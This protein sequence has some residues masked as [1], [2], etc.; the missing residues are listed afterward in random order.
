MIGEH[1]NE[2]RW[3]A[4]IEDI[5]RLMAERDCHPSDC[6]VLVPY[7]QL[8]AQA[9]QAWVH[10]AGRE[11]ACYLPQI[12][13]TQNWARSL[14]AARGGYRAAE[15]DLREQVAFDQLSAAHWLDALGLS[16]ERDVL[17]APLMEAAGSLAR[18]AAAIAPG[19][20]AAWRER[21]TQEL[22]AALGAQALRHE[23]SVAQ[24]A[25]AWAGSS[26]Y[27][28]DILF[29]QQV[30]LLLVLQGWQADPLAQAL[31]QR[32]GPRA[33]ALPL[34][35]VH[36]QRGRIALQSAA[37][38][39][40]EAERAA[41]C[42]LRHLQQGR[43][44]VGLIAQDRLL[45]RR[46]VALLAGRGVAIRDETGWKL[47]TTHAAARLMALLRACPAGATCDEVLAWIKPLPGLDAGQL[48]RVEAELRDARL[49]CWSDIGAG[50][51]H[52]WAL[53]AVL[54][55][56]QQALRGVRP[57]VHWLEQLRS[58]LRECGMWDG[59]A[60]DV[61][62]QAIFDALCLHDVQA[63]D[64]AEGQRLM[65]ARAFTQWVAACLEAGTFTPVHPPRS[66]V[67]V[68]PMAQLLGRSLAALVLP[69]ADEVQMPAWPQPTGP[70]TARQ[71]QLLGLLA[72]Q[73]LAD[74]ARCAWQHVL[75]HATVDVLWRESDGGERRMASAWV[76][77][78]TLGAAQGGGRD[79][80]AADARALHA[81][82]LQ[83][84]SM[85][86][87]CGDGLPVERLSAS[88][89][90]DLRNCPYRF[91]ALRQ[92]ALS[93][94]Q[95]IEADVDR[96]D[97]GN[98]LHATLFEFH[99]QLQAES[100]PNEQRRMQLFDQ[101]AQQALRQTGMNRADFL[102]YEAS[103]PIMR[104]GYLQ[105]LA[106]H[107]AS[108]HRF[109]QA[110]QW[111]ERDLGAVKLVGKIDRMDRDAQGQALLIDYKSES[112]EKTRERIKCADEDTQLAFYAALVGEEPV[113]AAYLNVGERGL[114]KVYAQDEVLHWRD[115][116]VSAVHDEM[117][118]LHGGE[119]LRALGQGRSCEHCKA[120]G[121]CR[122]DF[123]QD[124]S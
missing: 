39:S 82:D 101:A 50:C 69:G 16:S 110:E 61:A 91:F 25:L 89:Y 9:R 8:M 94:V 108:G 52:A 32:M 92:L 4:L 109:V 118:R 28:T 46:V 10:S 44:P 119:P 88:A 104:Q 74:S 65:S 22:T 35:Q 76:Q 86:K 90:D 45:T 98:W 48:E 18:R 114:T 6:V 24:L 47:S 70:W 120:R 30:P 103:V 49:R 60:A 122:R 23:A 79:D 38:R 3:R 19:E 1:F 33:V 112:V 54:R 99:A 87:A 27:E 117:S 111:L 107:E 113:A 21:L 17:M 71:R 96:R 73:D 51:E 77:A 57:V 75:A 121:L 41:A 68:L 31:M 59:L 63:L 93:P 36:E 100:A 13:T 43:E 81:I 105:W 64:G 85:A 7:A 102:P 123:V 55:P 78:L 34:A 116:I 83:P 14:W 42:V 95:E 5:G 84:Q 58:V 115:R 62:G 66:Q 56:W 11:R 20:R 72:A 40:D 97:F 106:E 53:T 2:R 15:H 12:E 80:G 26:S 67:V 124:G 29:E 37:D